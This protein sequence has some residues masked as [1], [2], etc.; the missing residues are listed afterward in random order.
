[1]VR[2]S[3]PE[4]ANI[5]GRNVLSWV[6]WKSMVAGQLGITMKRQGRDAAWPLV[7]CK[8]GHVAFV[9]NDRDWNSIVELLGDP[10]LESDVFETSEGRLENRDHYIEIFRAWAKRRTK[11][12]INTAFVEL[13]IPGAPA[14]TISDLFSDKLLRR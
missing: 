6:N 8:D 10:F 7:E 5:D 12:E 13:A 14:Y 9:H 3:E 4:S 2:F 11:E 1:M